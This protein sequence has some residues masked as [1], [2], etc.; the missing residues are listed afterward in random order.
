MSTFIVREKEIGMK[1]KDFSDHKLIKLEIITES[2][3]ENLKYLQ[4]KPKASK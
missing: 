4:I 2:I 3:Q 1:K